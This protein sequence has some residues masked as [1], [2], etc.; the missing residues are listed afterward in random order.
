MKAHRRGVHG[1]RVGTVFGIELRIDWSVAVIFWL[2][3]WGLATISFPALAG[4]YT[5][6]EYWIVGF[7]TTVVFLASLLAHELSHS[8]VANRRDIKVR[9]ITLW[10]FGGVSSLEGE[11]RTPRSDF[12]IAI[13]GPATSIVLGFV[14]G[15]FAILLYAI[16]TAHLAI[17][18]FGWLG[19][20]NLVL[21]F[22]NLMPAAP[23]DGGRV[24]RAW[25]WHRTGDH[26]AAALS[27][28]RAGHVFGWVLVGLGL[29]EFMAGATVGGIWF[30]LLGWFLLSASRS[31]EMHT[32]VVH[33]L[34]DVRVRDVMT[35]SPVTAPAD[36]SIAEL[37]DHFVLVHHCSAFPLVDR[38]GRV[39]ALVT[40]RH[41]RSVPVA[42]RASTVARDVATPIAD[43]P[44]A[45]PDEL[46]VP[47]LQR[48]AESDGRILVMSEDHLA[49]IIT[50]TDIT[51]ALHYHG[52]P[53]R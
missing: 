25:L 39:V 53:T 22:F 3:V 43:V 29:L 48:A 38:D 51:R 20:I 21:A 8:I 9:D 33:A 11:A 13:A 45:A 35:P 26:D 40:L 37:L 5:G 27:A 50:P 2:L 15:A 52:V 12:E 32:V 42:K 31:E 10:L 46:L 19:V 49:G 47:V 6:A 24:L 34:H 41:C 16:G 36:T 23:L 18:A 7:F 17:A 44:I 14:F 30:M 4:G 1:F 28:A